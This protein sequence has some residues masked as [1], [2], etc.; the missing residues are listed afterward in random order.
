MSPLLSP[1]CS[2]TSLQGC[3][4]PHFVLTV[5]RGN[6]NPLWYSYLEN[7]MDRGA[8][9]ATVRGVAESWTQLSNVVCRGHVCLR[10]LG[11]GQSQEEQPYRL[12]VWWGG[13]PTPPHQSPMCPQKCPWQICACCTEVTA[14]TGLGAGVRGRCSGAAD[15]WARPLPHRASLQ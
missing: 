13:L 11:P 14:T 8:W 5:W 2:L 4:P 7:L 6:G 3:Q 10:A 15:C 1:C 12:Q 9:Q